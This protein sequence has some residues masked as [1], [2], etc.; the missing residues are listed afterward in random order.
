MTRLKTGRIN[1]K[2]RR[3][4]SQLTFK[5]FLADRSDDGRRLSV[6]PST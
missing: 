1:R 4:M 6:G 3:E 2:S 5:T